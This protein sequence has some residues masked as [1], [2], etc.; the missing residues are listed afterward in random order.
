VTTASCIYEGWIRHRRFAP[1]DHVFR[2]ALYMLYVDLDELPELFDDRWL[3]SARRPALAWLRREDHLGDPAVPLRDA[4]AELVEA[5]TGRAPAGPIRLLTHPRYFGYGMNPVSFYYCF[6]EDGKTVE[7]IVAEVHNTPWGERHCYVLDAG[8]DEGT[9][10]RRRYRFPKSFHVSPFMGMDQAYDWRFVEPDAR[11][12]VHMESREAGAPMLDAT[13]C[14]RRRP[15][16][17]P[18]LA[19]VLVRYPFMT[20]KVITGIYW[21]ALRLWLKRVPFHPHPNHGRLSE[22]GS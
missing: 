1:R 5:R 3:W 8:L 19:R 2:Y 15:F 21:Q 14:L 20:G 10:R 4:V 7:T 22:I 11:L 18:A 13:M 16:S 12:T 17:G 6:D 9:G